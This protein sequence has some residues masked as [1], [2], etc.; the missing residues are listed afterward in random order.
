MKRIDSTAAFTMIELLMVIAIIACLAALLMPTLAAARQK[1]DSIACMSNLRQIGI[2]SQLYAAEHSQT[3]PVIEPWPSQPVY[4]PGD[5]AQSIL[6]ALQPYGVTAATLRC[7]ADITGPNYNAQE[8]SSYEWCPMANGQNVQ[9]VKL[10]WGGNVTG[11]TLSNLL[12][13]FDYSNAHNNTSNVLFGDG[14]VASGN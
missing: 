14:H 9:S 2:A 4:S 12:M 7:R 13:A 8:G 5:G 11:V 6:A 1:A 10:V 3:T